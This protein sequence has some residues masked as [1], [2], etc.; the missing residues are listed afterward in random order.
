[1]VS[2]FKCQWLKQIPHLRAHLPSLAS[3]ARVLSFLGL[4][5]VLDWLTLEAFNVQSTVYELITY[6]PLTK[7]VFTHA[8]IAATQGSPD[9]CVFPWGH[10]HEV[11][12]LSGSPHGFFPMCCTYICSWF[13]ALGYNEASS[14]MTSPFSAEQISP[15]K[16]SAD[17]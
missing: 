13:W 4:V 6:P 17:R 10:F 16:A 7:E 2:N 12:P 9:H 15:F 14:K 3:P 5:R 1:M 8:V 11:F